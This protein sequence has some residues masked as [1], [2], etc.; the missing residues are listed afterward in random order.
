MEGL[1]Y[2]KAQ[3]SLHTVRPGYGPEL[4]RVL[5]AE[6]GGSPGA[7]AVFPVRWNLVPSQLEGWAQCG[8][9]E[10]KVQGRVQG[11]GG[12]TEERT[13]GGHWGR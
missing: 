7:A 6:V 8:K 12:G 3:R 9:W 4:G 11:R 5:D 13:V 1:L 10:E 2:P